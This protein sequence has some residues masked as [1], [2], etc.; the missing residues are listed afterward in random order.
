MK[1]I[2]LVLALLLACA[3]ASAADYGREKK[4][5]D[6]ILPG[7]VVGDAVWL[8]ADGHKFLAL[9]AAAANPKAGV[10]L[11]HGIGVHPDWGLIGTLRTGLADLD[12]AT[13]SIQMPVLGA[14]AKPED[15]AAAMPEAASRI[16][17]A[18]KF[19]EEK[20]P[21]KPIAIVAHS[22][23][24]RMACEYLR[25]EPKA[26]LAAYV[27]IGL[28]GPC[29]PM[30][31]VRPP[32]FDLYGSADLPQVLSSARERERSVSR[33]PLSQQAR[34][35]GADHFFTGKEQNLLRAVDLYLETVTAPR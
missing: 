20:A 15:Y 13:L 14:E 22:L 1:R 33:R 6:E 35:D 26:P 17:A 28:S 8:E 29:P 9:Y 32:I 11:V 34:V 10:I 3:A 18:V 7:L 16:A 5:A 25:R 19:L 27:A 4:W 2:G 30:D 21:T 12:Y 24:A 31:A 23:G